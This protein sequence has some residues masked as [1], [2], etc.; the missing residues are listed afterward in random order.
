[1]NPRILVVCRGRADA[2]GGDQEPAELAVAAEIRD[3]SGGA[4]RFPA[5]PLLAASLKRRACAPACPLRTR[6]AVTTSCTASKM[7]S[8]RAE[9]DSRREVGQ[10][11]RVKHGFRRHPLIDHRAGLVEPGS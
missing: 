4:H 1:M 8:G 2:A 7:W 11:R 5:A 10:H 3:G 9:R 6:V